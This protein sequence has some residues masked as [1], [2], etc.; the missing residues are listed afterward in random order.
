MT[1]T[2][3]R[4]LV[5]LV[6]VM[7][8]ATAP[9]AMAGGYLGVGVGI[10]YSANESVDETPVLIDYDLG[11]RAAQVTA[12]YAFDNGWRLELEG[13]YRTN[14]LEILEFDDARGIVNNDN[15]DTTDVSSLMLNA[16]YEFRWA[17]L[18]PYVGVG[19]G[20]AK[21]S[22]A[23][24][25]AFADMLVL[26]DSG[27]SFAYQGIIG[28]GAPLG[29]R[30]RLDLDYRYWRNAK[31]NLVGEM[32]ESFETDH[33]IHQASLSLRYAFK[34][35]ERIQRGP[36]NSHAR[37]YTELRLGAVAAE[38]SDIEDGLRD[39]NFDAFDLGGALALA[40]GY[41]SEGATGRGWRAEL[42]LYRWEN[43][44]DVVDFGSVRGE[45]RSSG[46]AETVNLGVNLIYDFAGGAVL[47]P[48]AGIG[49]GYTW[50]DY[51]IT[52]REGGT[53]SLYVDDSDSTVSVQ[54]LLGVS[55]RVS[56]RLTAS[57]NYRY[58][59]APSVT[60]ESPPTALQS[61]WDTEHSAHLL[62]LGLRYRLGR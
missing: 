22:Y 58:W 17:V 30:F 54:A 51:D 44:S 55:A 32:G 46:Q 31:L 60:L 18:R 42:E 20:F 14:D 47:Q 43:D 7:A 16:L 25:D 27:T 45:A 1:E 40:V 23:I 48:Y 24:N 33:P 34:A 62:L 37:W 49:V 21:V 10:T 4:R 59:W 41:A 6:G 13:A 11:F 35:R 52:L 56:E 28:V 36:A 26:D 39:T 2:A 29:R 9:A 5:R 3:K 61:E 50:I 15:N 12:G 8:L 53:S 38:D 57:F 19:V